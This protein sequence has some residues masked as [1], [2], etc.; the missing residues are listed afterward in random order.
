MEDRCPVRLK[1]GG[2][3]ARS[4]AMPRRYGASFMVLR[5]PGASGWDL[6][7][8]GRVQLETAHRKPSKGGVRPVRIQIEGFRPIYNESFS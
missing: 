4:G 3:G 1:P 8:V 6:D 2:S 7:D 5:A